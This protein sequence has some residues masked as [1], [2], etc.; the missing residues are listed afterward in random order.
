MERKQ[1]EERIRYL[2]EYLAE[3]AR[4]YYELDS[5]VIEDEEY[6]RLNRELEDLEAQYPEFAGDDSVTQRIGGAASAKFSNV[7]H[8]VKMESL[9]DLFSKEEVA[10]FINRMRENVGDPVFSV[11][12]KIDGLSVSLEYENGRFVRGSTRGDGTVGE[13]VT[14]NL[15]VINSIPKSIP[16]SIERLEVRGEV[17]MPRKSFAELVAAQEAD[18]V[19]T[20]KNPRNAAAGSLRQKDPSVTAKR[21]L[22]IFIFNVQSTTEEITGHVESLDWLKSIG[23]NVIPSYVM[24]STEEEVFAEIDR[25]GEA[26]SSLEYDTDGAVIKLNSFAQRQQLGSTVKVPRWAVAFKYPAEIKATKLLDIEVTVGRTGV[27]TPTAVF[28]PVQLGGTTVSRASL[29]NQDFIDSLG[30]RIGDTVEVR[31]AG[32]IIPEVIKAY[33]HMPGAEIFRLP[34][35]CPSCGE[36]VVRFSDESAVRCINPECPGQAVRN[37]IYFASKDA[38]DING[39]GPSIVGQ[40]VNAGL[41]NGAADLYYLDRDDVLKL[42]NFKEKA[43]DNLLSAIEESKANNLDRLITAFGIRNCG[44]KAAALICERYGDIDS[45][46]S[47]EPE[48]IAS[49]PGIGDKIAESVAGFFRKSGTADLVEK[50]RAAGVNLVYT[51]TRTGSSLTGRTVVVTGTLSKFSRSEIEK[52]INDNGGHAS[53][54]VSKKTSFVVAG[55]NAGSK[56]DKARQLGIEVLTEDEFLSRFSPEKTE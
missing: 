54:S 27:L 38:M 18:G 41:I 39:L 24:C 22:D 37:I 11:E 44:G 3:N 42:D 25:I 7:T 19:P 21:N 13:D 31:K 50:L 9:A 17:F 20:F 8:Q 40:L 29:H 56:L 47:A 46:M 43:C 35:R 4:L 45:I 52:Y 28:E 33:D 49:I 15:A 30:I 32:E 36:D 53:S 34:D 55:E 5:P 48:E 6:D 14:E 26:R 16:E 2:R 23:F 10:S 51:S 12:P 1:A